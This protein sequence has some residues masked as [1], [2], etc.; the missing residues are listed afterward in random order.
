LAVNELGVLARRADDQTGFGAAVEHELLLRMRLIRPTS[1][2]QRR[3]PMNRLSNKW[4]LTY[5]SPGRPARHAN[6]VHHFGRP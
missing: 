4:V 2:D 5:L 3:R 1:Y 6:A